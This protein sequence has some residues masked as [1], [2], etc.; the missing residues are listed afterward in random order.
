MA[1]YIKDSPDFGWKKSLRNDEMAE[2]RDLIERAAVVKQSLFRWLA[3]TRDRAVSCATCL[4]PCMRA[5]AVAG[6]CLWRWLAWRRS[7]LAERAS[8]CC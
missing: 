2:G 3:E 6:W 4:P 1:H 7:V 8:C 5:A